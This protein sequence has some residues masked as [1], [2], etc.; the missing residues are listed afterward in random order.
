MPLTGAEPGFPRR[1]VAPGVFVED[2]IPALFADL[3]L[4]PAERAIELRL[5]IVLRGDSGGEWTL[6]FIEGELGIATVR[7]LA[8]DLSVIL[9]VED[10]RAAL[11]EGRPALV[12]DALAVRL[13][14]AQ[15]AR[16]TQ[17]GQSASPLSL[18]V[19]PDPGALAEL[20]KLRGYLE[21]RV[22]AA[23]P[24]KASPSDGDPFGAV[25]GPWR[26]GILFGPGTLPT[27]PDAS[28]ELGAA[29]AEAIHRGQLHPLE[30]L[31]TGELRLEGDLG[32]ILQI[33]AI[34]M[35]ASLVR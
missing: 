13:R 3:D 8:C 17:A 23:E 30:A 29:Q 20:R 32:L 14:P 28:V 9:S 2:V 7:D 16:P 31:M 15:A 25:R 1:P 4:T 33:Q 19:L 24:A 34:A 10:W 26:L 21:I 5:G 6:H 12:A 35:M 18:A 27:S 11:W 22:A